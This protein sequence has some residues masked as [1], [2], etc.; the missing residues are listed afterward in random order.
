MS[1]L[2]QAYRDSQNVAQWMDDNHAGDDSVGFATAWAEIQ[3]VIRELSAAQQSVQR[4]AD[5]P[6]EKHGIEYCGE[7]YAATIVNTPAASASR[8]G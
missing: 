3:N 8:C 4:T 2:K 1:N 6:C 5:K 7:C